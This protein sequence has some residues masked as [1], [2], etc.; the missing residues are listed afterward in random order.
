MNIVPFWYIVL[1]IILLFYSYATFTSNYIYLLWKLLPQTRMVYIFHTGMFPY[2]C[3]Y[4]AYPFVLKFTLKG[5][6]L[7]DLG[8]RNTMWKSLAFENLSHTFNASLLY[9]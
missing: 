9:W 2:L 8:I 5:N 3:V 4:Y 6:Q 1:L 7:V